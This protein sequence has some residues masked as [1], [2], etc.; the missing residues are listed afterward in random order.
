MKLFLPVVVL[1]AFAVGCDGHVAATKLRVAVQDSQGTRVYRLECDPA[2]GTMRHAAAVCSELRR[3]PG[4]LES[5]SL[6][7]CGPGAV[8]KR[9]IRVTGID[10]GKSVHVEFSGVCS[11]SG[12]GF[13]AWDDALQDAG[14]GTAGT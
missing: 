5:P 14:P 10:R 6:V 3:E 8:S 7:L 4:L 12:N 2:G 11:S 9:G 1:A 13:G